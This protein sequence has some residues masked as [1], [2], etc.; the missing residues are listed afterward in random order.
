[1]GGED[2]TSLFNDNSQFESQFRLP[3]IGNNQR[4]QGY[5]AYF[6]NHH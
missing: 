2:V 4:N 5:Y 3:K 6:A 1:M